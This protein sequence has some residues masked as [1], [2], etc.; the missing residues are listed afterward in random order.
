MIWSWRFIVTMSPM[1]QKKIAEFIAR[2]DFRRSSYVGRHNRNARCGGLQENT[3]ERLLPGCVE[4]KHQLVENTIHIIAHAEKMNPAGQRRRPSRVP[5]PPLQ[6]L[7]A[8]TEY[9]AFHVAST[10]VAG[11]GQVYDERNLV[12]LSRFAVTATRQL[13]HTLVA[14]PA[15]RMVTAVP[16]VAAASAVGLSA[17]TR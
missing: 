8:G 3:A 2:Q 5:E 6:Q 13:K 4:Q 16:P 14:Q 11:G 7:V 15:W 10:T 12:V 17:T 9:A 1:A